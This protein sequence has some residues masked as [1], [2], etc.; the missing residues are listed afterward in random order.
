MPGA[1]TCVLARVR[2][3]Y[4]VILV[5]SAALVMGA[6]G[7]DTAPP[8]AAPGDPTLAAVRS[9]I[10]NSTCALGSCHAPATNAAKLNLSETGI[11]HLLVSHQSCLFPDKFL[12]VP[13]KPEA[14][15]LLDKLRGTNLEG[16]PNPDCG[17]T[18]ER[19]PLGQPPLPANKLAQIEEWIR[20][21]ADCG[22]EVTPIDAAPDA[23]IDAPEPPPDIVSISA[24]T[25]TILVGQRIQVMITLS[26]GAPA[27]SPPVMLAV[28]DATVFSVDSYVLLDPGALSATFDVIGQAKGTARITASLGTSMMSITITV[29]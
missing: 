2:R 13:G 29:E 22:G 5:L 14:S 12:V 1:V 15:F 17:T 3:S 11:C 8:D 28:D 16:V 6:C 25:P 18:N 24:A 10:F 19:M 20:S 7:P 9:D 27:S 23:E 21:G 26:R 4:T